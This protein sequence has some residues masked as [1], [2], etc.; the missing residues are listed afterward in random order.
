[1]SEDERPL[2][3][4]Q[5]WLHDYLADG[6]WHTGDEIRQRSRLALPKEISLHPRITDLRERGFRIEHQRA[7][8]GYAFLLTGKGDPPVPKRPDPKAVQGYVFNN[9]AEPED[10][11]CGNICQIVGRAKATDSEQL[12]YGSLFLV[13]FGDGEEDTAFASELQPW[14]PT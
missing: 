13:R 2:S 8:R 14:Y 6:K 5:Q 7:G 3:K 4:T 1:M 11:R 9:A 12:T 10:P